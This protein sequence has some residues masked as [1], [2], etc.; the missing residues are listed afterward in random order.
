MLPG[1]ALEGHPNMYVSHVADMSNA[2]GL[3][4]RMADNSP[5]DRRA[6]LRETPR[7]AEG[8][9]GISAVRRVKSP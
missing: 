6:Q 9:R 8:L 7:G 2:F 5:E 4:R 1:K 3:S